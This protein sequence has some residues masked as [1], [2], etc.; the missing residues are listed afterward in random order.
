M[1]CRGGELTASKSSGEYGLCIRPLRGERSRVPQG[2]ENQREERRNRHFSAN[3]AGRPAKGRADKRGKDLAGARHLCFEDA[4]VRR[5]EPGID[6]LYPRRPRVSAT[7][8]FREGRGGSHAQSRRNP[9]GGNVF[10]EG[11]GEGGIPLPQISVIGFL[12][13]GSSTSK[14]FLG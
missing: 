4:A 8:T 13:E 11:G 1:K 2:P 6:S 7:S 9:L 12:N 5:T 14:G 3:R 10:Q